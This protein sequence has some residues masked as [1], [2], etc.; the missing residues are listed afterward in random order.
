MVPG[1]RAGGV[2]EHVDL[3]QDVRDDRDVVRVRGADE[4]VVPAFLSK[5]TPNLSHV[6]VQ[7]ALGVHSPVGPERLVQ[8]LSRN[9]LS[10]ALDEVEQDMAEMGEM[11]QMR[12]YQEDSD[13][14]D[15]AVLPTSQGTLLYFNIYKLDSDGNIEKKVFTGKIKKQKDYLFGKPDSEK[16]GIFWPLTTVIPISIVLIPV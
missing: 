14:P 5:G 13:N 8:L 6:G 9:E 15:N 1:A 10:T 3:L 11:E 16:I 2:H 4:A 12:E 7:Q